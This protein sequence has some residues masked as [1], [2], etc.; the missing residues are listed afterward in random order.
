MKLSFTAIHYL[1]KIYSPIQKMT[2]INM[3]PLLTQN[4]TTSQKLHVVLQCWYN[5][6]STPISLMGY[7]EDN[8]YCQYKMHTLCNKENRDL[9][10]K[11]HTIILMK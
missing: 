9:F 3:H 10:T 6:L 7:I 2:F 4:K 8:N 5:H 1:S 11:F